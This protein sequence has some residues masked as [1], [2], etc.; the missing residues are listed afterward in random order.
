MVVNHY[1]NQGT[2]N[3][4]LKVILV[5]ESGS[6]LDKLEV[7]FCNTNY[8]N[9]MQLEVP[10]TEAALPCCCAMDT[11]WRRNGRDW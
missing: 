5:R 9:Y 2:E 1:T 3:V 11:L 7:L 10:N 8:I 4:S 6:S